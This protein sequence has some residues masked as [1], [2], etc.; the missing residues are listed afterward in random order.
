M[1]TRPS[2]PANAPW[3]ARNGWPSRCST[4]CSPIFPQLTRLAQAP[5][6]AGCAVH[7]AERSLTLDWCAPQFVP[8][9]CIEIEAGRHPVVQARLQ[10]GIE[11]RLHRQPRGSTPTRACRSS[12]APTWAVNRPTCARWHSSFARQHGQ[13]RTCRQLP[14]RPHRRHP[15]PASAQPTTWANAQSTFMLEMV[16]AAQILHR[17]HTPTA[18]C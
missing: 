2:R 9:P 15:H 10:E 11:R 6:H 5:G 13:P 3:R 14:P 18:W 1:R 8:E 16:E 12:P 17:R 4:N 7:L